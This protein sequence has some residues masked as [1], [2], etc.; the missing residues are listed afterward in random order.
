MI[1]GYS[2][3]AGNVMFLVVDVYKKQDL[4]G[5]HSVEAMLGDTVGNAKAPPA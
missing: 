3:Y 2:H 1:A 5:F 4:A